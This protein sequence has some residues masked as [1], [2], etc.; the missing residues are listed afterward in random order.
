MT[1]K[2]FINSLLSGGV[3]TNVF[4]N[5]LD[6]LFIALLVYG[7]IIFI[8]DTKAASLFKSIIIMFVLFFVIKVF[9]MDASTYLFNML[10]SN[11]FIILIVIFSPE[12]RAVMERIGRRSTLKSFFN[13]K[14]KSEDTLKV[15]DEICKAVSVLSDKMEGALIVIE[16]NTPLGEIIN[17]GTLIDSVVSEEILR[18]IFFKNSP[19]HDGAIVIRDN[20]IAAAG[21]ILPLSDK[22]ISNAFGTRHRACLGISEE[23]DAISIVV[24]EESGL[25]SLAMNNHLNSPIDIIQLK[26]ILIKELCAKK[27]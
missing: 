19:L 3:G 18:N 6:I 13:L 15:I 4:S 7:L 14:S 25:V 17:T 11:I 5:I 22:H 10:F 16:R 21:C 24:S 23:T 9:K 12:I 2:E 20:R 1:F 8:R 26:E 27:E